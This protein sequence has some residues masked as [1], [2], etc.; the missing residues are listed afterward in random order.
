MMLAGICDGD[1]LIVD[2]SVEVRSGQLVLATWEGNQ[3]T[4]KLL[5]VVGSRME[6]HSRNPDY[7]KIV[8]P[9]E[10]EVEMFAVTGVVRMLHPH[11]K[12]PR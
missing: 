6:L 3:P 12:R 2:R 1:I 8:L 5:K 7:A 10:T 11:R 9:A 4:C